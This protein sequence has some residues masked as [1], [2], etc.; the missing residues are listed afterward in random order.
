MEFF[1]KYKSA[2]LKDVAPGACIILSH[3]RGPEMVAIKIGRAEGEH[4]VFGGG[5]SAIV[6]LW[7]AEASPFTPA[8]MFLRDVE[9][10]EISDAGAQ[11]SGDP[12][13]I[14]FGKPVLGALHLFGGNPHVL[15]ED[16]H[17]H[18]SDGLISVRLTD[19]A[20]DRM[21]KDRVPWFSFWTVAV[22]DATRRMETIC[23]IDVRKPGP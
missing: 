3:S 12:A 16:K 7:S 9:V 10:L 8:F 19:G 18:Y 13:H 1:S 14:H 5:M 6:A 22:P 17:D 23:S 20:I 4:D 21:P 15:V 11:P 2:A